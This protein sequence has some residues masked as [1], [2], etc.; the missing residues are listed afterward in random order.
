MTIGLADTSIFVALESGRPFR[1]ELLP[2]VMRTSVITIGELRV[3]VL[4]A[5]DPAVRAARLATLTRAL[6][7]EPV[8]I[9]DAVAEAW[10]GLRVALADTGRRMAVNDSWIAATA[11]AMRIPIV[12]QDDDFLPLA[13]L[14]VIHV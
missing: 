2:D 9:D 8:P 4:I 10:A 6:R 7:F 13:G 14:D 3:G 5:S 12:T 11:I 1:T